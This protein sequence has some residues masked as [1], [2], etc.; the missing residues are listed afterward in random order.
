MK[1]RFMLVALLLCIVA[2]PAQVGAQARNV[3][4]ED[5]IGIAI[6][7]STIVGISRE[8]LQTSRQNVLSSYG[9][10]LPNLQMNAFGG[11][12]FVG[13]SET[14]AFDDQGR[15]IVG[16]GLDYPNYTFSLSSNIM[17]FNWGVNVKTA[18]S[19]K[20]TA[21][22]SEYDLQYQKDVV[23]ALVIREYYNY[24]RMQNLRMV[25]EESVEAAERNLQQVEAFFR[26]GSNTKADVLQAQ[27]R[28]GGTQLQLIAARNNEEIA[29]ARL[30]SRLNFSL[31]EDFA[32]DSSLDIV[33]VS[34]DLQNEVEYMLQNRSDL[35][36]RR[37]R[38][39]AANANID[40]AEDSR[41]P[42]IG[43]GVSYSWSD[44]E[45]PKNGNVFRRDYS[46][47]VGVSLN[48]PIFD[49][50]SS[51]A[52]ILESKAQHRVAE[53]NLQQ[54]KLDAILE[55]K[56]LYLVLRE[57]DERMRVSENT[58]A[59]AS[60]NLRLAEERYRVG[61]GTI[62]ETIDA[63]VSLTQAQAALVEAKC[64]YLIAKA[65]L[66]RAAGRPVHVD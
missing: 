46:W 29:K 55:L 62:L 54:A 7:Q 2:V 44:R 66:L 8:Q 41:W 26:I 25:Q 48:W 22:A 59:Q 37:K 1:T 39:R 13:P 6:D 38:V 19:A 17:L 49:R 53:Y 64:D 36:A 9:N 58:V 24:V 16:G 60:E 4:L 14:R 11:R 12:T 23:T 5:A 50:F 63:G 56:Q 51:K 40:V 43:A 15:P 52:R 10:F 18:N 33:K 47:G 61:A 20:S 35:Q 42:T 65:D 3:N 31:E 57:A 34:P 32:V 45:A 28:L 30:A 27:V 21:E